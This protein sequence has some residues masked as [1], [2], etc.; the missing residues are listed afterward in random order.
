MSSAD[1]RP[2]STAGQLCPLHFS[3]EQL[4]KL[5]TAA[6]RNETCRLE[7]RN[8]GFSTAD[9][10]LPAELFPYPVA[11]I[12]ESR[13]LDRLPGY[14][15][16]S[17]SITF[18]RHVS[19]TGEAGATS[20]GATKPELIFETDQ[21]LA[22]AVKLAATNG[23]SWEIINDWP[24]FQ[25]YCGTEL[26]KRIID[27]ENELLI[28]GDSGTVTGSGTTVDTSP[29]GMVGLMS[30]PGILTYDASVD[31]G[32]SGST[33]LSALDSVEKA[34]AELRVG[35]ALA[36]PDL[37]VLNPSTWSTIRRIKDGF[38]HF[39][40][41]PDPTSDQASELWGI[42]VLQTTQ[43]PPGV[44]LLLDTSELGYVAIRESL[45]MRIGYSSDDFARNILRTVAEERLVL[46]VTRPPAISLISNLPTS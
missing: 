14:A 36:V 40:V 13:L 15:I 42:D 10:L 31:T 26:Y 23:L 22:T 34:I 32:G 37:F 7:T 19:T 29:T 35:P 21:L 5:Q 17:P 45:S 2:T 44:G 1:Q 4:R 6:Q 41:Q 33:L 18:I 25:S 16:E 46:C 20:E 9:P 30:T 43:C 3:N 28:Q 24:A 27:I 38:G 12:H 39:M 11:A 8:P